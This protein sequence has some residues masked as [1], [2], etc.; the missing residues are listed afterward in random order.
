VILSAVTTSI[1]D[2]ELAPSKEIVVAEPI[3]VVSDS[4]GSASDEELG[5][6]QDQTVDAPVPGTQGKWVNVG[7]QSQAPSNEI[8]ETAADATN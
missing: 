4:E 6:S 7:S 2:S 3:Q 1:T 5:N 8:S